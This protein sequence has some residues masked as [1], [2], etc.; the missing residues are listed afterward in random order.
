[1]A[2]AM[3]LYAWVSGSSAN[4]SQ[5]SHEV[6]AMTP[7]GADLQ[8]KYPI[9]WRI[10]YTLTQPRLVHVPAQHIMGLM[11]GHFVSKAYAQYKPDLVVSVHPLMQARSMIECR[12]ACC[13]LL[14][15]GTQDLLCG[16]LGVVMCSQLQQAC[17]PDRCTLHSS[18]HV[19][20]GKASRC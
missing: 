5:L 9:L 18:A 2:A 1:V 13:S 3:V 8:V 15:R 4:R 19:R 11:V 16:S 7:A 14:W 6:L 20:N 17:P 12:T 10:G